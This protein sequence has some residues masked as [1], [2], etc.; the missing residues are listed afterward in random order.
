MHESTLQVILKYKKNSIKL[1]KKIEQTKT[2]LWVYI[3]TT[4]TY[5][6]AHE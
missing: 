6:V 2:K 4:H 3:Y 1:T 5:N